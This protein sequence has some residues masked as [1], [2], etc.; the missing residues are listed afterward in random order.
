MI[1][2]YLG[3]KANKTVEFPIPLMMLAERTGSVTFTA[4]PTGRK[5]AEVPDEWASSLLAM[6]DLY[7]VPDPSFLTV[8]TLTPRHKRS[9]R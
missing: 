3:P 7:Q 1:V 9:P 8:P 5:V 2:E 6:P 4:D